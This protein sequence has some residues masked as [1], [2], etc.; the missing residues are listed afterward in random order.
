VHRL[1]ALA[2]VEFA[3]L[4]SIRRYTLVTEAQRVPAL[5]SV[6]WR[7]TPLGLPTECMGSRLQALQISVCRVT[8]EQMR[9]RLRIA[10]SVLENIKSHRQAA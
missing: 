3:L 7:V 9:S 1:L 4:N 10:S 5:L 6:G 8:L 2:L